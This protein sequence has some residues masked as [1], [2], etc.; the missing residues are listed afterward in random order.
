MT[1]T[2]G[3]GGLLG[4]PKRMWQQVVDLLLRR[5]VTGE[6]PEGAELPAEAELCVELGVSRPPVREA[7]KVLREKGLVRT[8]QGRRSVVLPR[9][10]WNALDPDILTTELEN[11][12][13]HAR[14]FEDLSFVRI[15]LEA[16][17]ARLAAQRV[18]D[19]HLEAIRAEV[20][21]LE[22]TVVDPE[23]Y[24]D[25][26]V[27]FHELIMQAAGNHIAQA[28][29]QMISEPLRQSR[30]LTNR[31]PGGVAHAHEFHLRIFDRI[32]ARDPDGAAE[33]MR[34]HLEWSWRRF[35]ELLDRGATGRPED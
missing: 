20:D 34:E 12:Q 3:P 16:Q 24:L 29:M 30:R 32:A 19:E 10:S 18:T 11:P 5:I 17:M 15:A 8:D 6:Y 33:A 35:L 9:E 4:R 25:H 14:I 21:E 1:Q 13:R 22:K 26:D 31:I 27:R 7:M 2:P 28:I 23:V